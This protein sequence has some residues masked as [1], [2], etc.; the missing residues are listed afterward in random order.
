MYYPTDS[1]YTAPEDT[2]VLLLQVERRSD[3]LYDAARRFLISILHHQRSVISIVI[4]GEYASR[5][6]SIEF[7]K[8]YALF[9]V[10][11]CCLHRK[12]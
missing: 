12:E 9:S 5:V 6:R 4:N 3:G 7:D 8:C 2:Q 11:R 10:D 1:D